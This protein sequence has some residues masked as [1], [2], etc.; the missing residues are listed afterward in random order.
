MILLF[1]LGYIAIAI[2]CYICCFI[3]HCWK[4]KNERSNWSFNQYYIAYSDEMRALSII[5]PIGIPILLIILLFQLICK[6]IERIET[7][8]ESKFKI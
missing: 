2:L 8:I 4:F 6:I 5:W 1:L 3:W 7:I